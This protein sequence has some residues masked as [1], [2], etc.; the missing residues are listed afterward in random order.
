MEE[1]RK[2][3]G[4]MIANSPEPLDTLQIDNRD[5]D[6]NPNGKFYPEYEW[7]PITKEFFEACQE[8]SLGELLHDEVFGLFDAMSAIEMMD[9]K[10]DIGMGF[11]KNEPAPH[12]FETAVAAG[13]LKLSNLENSELIGI[14]DSL[15]SCLVSWLE[16]HSLDQILFTCLYLHSPNSIE[17]KSLRTF[18]LAVRR[19]ITLIKDF[20]LEC[21][22]NEEEDF[23][24]FGSSSLNFF[25]HVPMTK[26]ISTLREAEDD[27]V[28]K[29]KNDSNPEDIIAVMNRLRFMR[30]LFQSL[31]LFWPKKDVSPGEAE[32]AEIQRN[33][34]AALELVPFIR[35]TIEKGTQPE[36]NSESPNPMGFSPRV[37]QR[38]LPP[39]FPRSAKVKDRLSSYIFLEELVQ[40]L[41]YAC[42]VIHQKDYHSALNFFIDFSKKSG[43][44]L[45]SRSV[46]QIL[47]LGN[48]R[49]ILGVIPFEEFLKESIKNF[50]AP[51]VLM[52]RNPL[53]NLP[54]AKTYVDAFFSY[55]NMHPFMYFLQIC[56]YNR[57][58]QRDKLSRLI[59]EGF[60][61]LLDEAGRI[62]AY[63]N[64]LATKTESGGQH[65]AYF[66]TWTL[67]HCLRAMSLY[68]LS[69]FE[70][71]L[72][73]VHEFL[74]IYWYLFEFL[75]SFIISALTRADSLLL[76]Q[77]NYQEQQI[78]KNNTKQ[79]KLKPKKKKN[80]QKP[81][82]SEIIYNHALQNMCGGYY[83]AMAGF[84]KDERI[85]QPMS[86][87]DNEKIRFNHRFA[88]FINLTSPPPIPYCEFV[89]MRTCILV[90]SST[91]LFLSAA[92][93]F[94]QART[95]LESI[96]N[97][98]Q[99]MIQ[100]IQIAK[101]NFIVTNLLA[102]GHKKESK[103]QPDFDFSQ[104]RYFPIIKI[105]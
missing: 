65:I 48:R 1:L 45:L 4:L 77:E 29:S 55:C 60:A 25:D 104:N 2:L 105:N 24:L 87:F 102:N 31:Y 58:R 54:Q 62:D 98:D 91:E 81:Y 19:I 74:Y 47:Y 28:K 101:V 43:H 23:Q 37:N 46:L 14:F 76:E 86:K 66:G 72:Y 56:G 12:T 17:N 61:N 99:E 63:L 5:D 95:I 30:F 71:E 82:R 97:P 39:T 70:L 10:M 90:L 32:I 75:Y 96:Q 59:Q 49:H 67:Y 18:C 78:N 89:K 35:K 103:S 51:P 92:K 64:V 50:I 100:M 20:I 88:P 53:A 57:A 33:L 80:H 68:L 7:K 85:R 27:L 8:L 3:E 73:S 11:N 84:T 22:V 83:K 38:N 13:V 69:G 36:P 26:V 93:H 41:K 6:S 52:P 15:F 9:P 44:C 94:H 79:R 40:R 42:K 21:N 34:S 16:G